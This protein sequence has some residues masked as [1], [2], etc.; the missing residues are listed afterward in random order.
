LHAWSKF[1]SY[2]AKSETADGLSKGDVDEI[3]KLV[4]FV[5]KRIG[6]GSERSD[7]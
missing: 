3:R 7:R 1:V 5:G 6:E 4:D 2:R